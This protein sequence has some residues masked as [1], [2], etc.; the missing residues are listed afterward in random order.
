[1]GKWE[2]ADKYGASDCFECGCCSYVCPADIP[3]VAYVRKAKA[4]H[5]RRGEE[6]KG[7][8]TDMANN[9]LIVS[10]PPHIKGKEL[11]GTAMRDVA[12]A[13]IPVIAVSIGFFRLYAVVNL[14]AAV[15][16]RH[17]LRGGDAQ[18]NGPRS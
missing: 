6:V 3:H 1:M 18:D 16:H 15:R 12:I 2:L 17:R 14:A 7:G 9:D 10:A 13:L 11:I 8:E 5:R 4:E